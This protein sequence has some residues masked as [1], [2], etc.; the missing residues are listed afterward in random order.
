MEVDDRLHLVLHCCEEDGFQ[1]VEIVDDRTLDG[2]DSLEDIFPRLHG[3]FNVDM[4]QGVEVIGRRLGNGEHVSKDWGYDRQDELVCAE[5]A[6][7]CRADD[8]ICVD[9][10]NGRLWDWGGFSLRG[11]GFF[12]CHGGEETP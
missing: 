4:R 9:A 10:E 5:V 2:V 8:H 12:G 6:G 11:A 3:L 1:I 7:P